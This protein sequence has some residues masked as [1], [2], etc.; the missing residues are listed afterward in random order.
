MTEHVSQ[1]NLFSLDDAIQGGY[2]CAR[3]ISPIQTSFQNLVLLPS[4][5]VKEPRLKNS[6]FTLIRPFQNGESVGL[7]ATIDNNLE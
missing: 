5:T 7:A 3:G 2:C 1:K 6:S 4:P